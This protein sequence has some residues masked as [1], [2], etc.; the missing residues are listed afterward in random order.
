VT[1]PTFSTT[2][3]VD[4]LIVGAGSAG[5]VIAK[6]I[7][8][9][10]F[11]VVVLEQ[12]PYLHERDF[13]HDEIRYSVAAGLTNDTR[14]QPVTYRRSEADQARPSD[15]PR[16][17]REY[18]RMFETYFNRTMMLLAH[19]TSLAQAKNT[20]R[21]DPQVKDAWGLPAI[22]VTFD[23]HPD[24]LATMKWMLARQIEILEAAGAQ[25]TWSQPYDV[26][27]M[28]PSRHLMGIC[29]MG[30]NPGS[31]V[32]NAYGRTHDIPNLFLVDG[33]NFV[34]SGRQ[35]PTATIQALAYRAADYAIRSAKRGELS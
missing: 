28:M 9:G 8:A 22:R 26:V 23:Y 24:D 31:S 1:G 2:E 30:N 20:I 10:G 6:E 33:S 4:F 5:G 19:T 15:A 27:D 16:W 11:N 25:K 21:L 13:S 18:K 32:V 29:R 7:S 17:G 3:P 35:Q 12:G 34:T 14:I